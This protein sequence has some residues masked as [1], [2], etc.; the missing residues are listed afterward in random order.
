MP[1]GSAFTLQDWDQ[2]AAQHRYGHFLQSSA[3][4]QLKSNHGWR[5]TW[6]CVLDTSNHITGGGLVLLRDLP[7]KLGKLAYMP[8]GPV[9]DWDTP[10]HTSK[11]LSHVSASAKKHGAIALIIEPSLMDTPHDEKML[12]ANGYVPNSFTVQPRR[13]IWVNLDVDAENDIL[14]KMKQKTRYNI[15]LARRKGVIVREANADDLPKFYQMMAVTSARDGFAVH[16]DAY[17]DDFLRLFGAGGSDVAR[18]LVAEHPSL[19]GVLLAGAVVTAYAKM[20]IYVYGA[21]ANEHRELMS[22]YLLQWEGMR[23]CRAR[24]CHT[25]DLW[26]VPDEDEDK[27]EAEFDKR[28]DGLWGVYRFKRGFG[29][30][31]VRQVGA[32]VNV[33]A[34]LRWQAFLLARKWRKQADAG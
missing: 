21:S 8:R 17:Y 28:H 12:L 22:T 15:G 20:G 1:L 11:V 3:W 16:S 7:A 14:A 33:L 29:G 30:Q 5:A 4:G 27:L 31:L 9:V 10:P 26:G 6:S 19:P 24:G 32:W 13:S 2:F 25:Y 18:L 34:P 23:W